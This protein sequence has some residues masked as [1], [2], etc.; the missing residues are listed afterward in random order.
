MNT[1][2][3]IAAGERGYTLIELSVTMGVFLI[4]MSFAT[5]FL[6]NQLEEAVKTETQVDLQQNARVSFRTLLRELR[7]ANKLYQATERP[8]RKNK[9][10]F[11]VDLDG[12]ALVDGSELLT[13][14]KKGSKL[15]RG[16]EDDRGQPL[17]EDVQTLEFTYYGSNLERLDKNPVDGIV[18]ET[19]LDENANGIID[20]GELDNVTRI[21][22]SLTVAS[23]FES[24]L[25]S[26][27]AWLRN[28]VVG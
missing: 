21:T 8:T 15:F 16:P 6:F 22:V 20:G 3:R 4:F 7:Q 13:Y 14:Y 9:V 24:Q 12:D 10:S 1:D 25:Y 5:P 17:A 11:W 23:G 26:G 18:S 27:T 28:R 2:R 19:E